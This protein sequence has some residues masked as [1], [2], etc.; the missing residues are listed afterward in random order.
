MKKI[1]SSPF[2]HLSHRA[3][4]AVVDK[5]L[6]AVR[7]NHPTYRQPDEMLRESIRAGLKRARSHG[8]VDEQSLME[9][10]LVMFE[11]APNFDQHPA[12]ALVLADP[13]LPAE[14]RWELVFDEEFDDAWY[15][16]AQPEFYDSAF[17]RDPDL[18]MPC[19]QAMRQVQ[20]AAG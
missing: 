5:I 2:A 14:E 11:I 12:I 4:P 16:A 7:E 18:L 6:A 8:L 19:R 10:V 9:Y 13:R 1:E 3:S 17:W 20:F 15:Q